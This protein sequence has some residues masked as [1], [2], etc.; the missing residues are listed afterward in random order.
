MSLPPQRYQDEPP[1]QKRRTSL[2]DVDLN[3][4]GT[5]ESMFNEDA[6]REQDLD[7]ARLMSQANADIAWMDD[8]EAKLS[9]PHAAAPA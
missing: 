7:A 8:E 5:A 3:W 1:E 2:K 9:T 4:G 6:Q